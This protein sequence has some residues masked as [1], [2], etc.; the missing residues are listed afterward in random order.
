[1]DL[2]RAECGGLRAALAVSPGL[3]MALA[4]AR[5]GHADRALGCDAGMREHLAQ[6]FAEGLAPGVG[7]AVVDM[8][9]F[10]RPWEFDPA[11]IAAPARLWI[12]GADRNVP[13]RSAWRLASLIPGCEL[14]ELD[15]FGHYWASRHIGEVLD[16][17]AGAVRR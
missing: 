13:V 16:W 3:A 14:S 1:M 5:A 2:T 11:L 9:L 4:G 12:G 8:E 7:G 6:T 15:G 10:A 17:I